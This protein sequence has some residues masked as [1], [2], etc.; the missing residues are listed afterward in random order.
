ME[1]IQ[2]TVHYYWAFAQRTCQRKVQ[3]YLKRLCLRFDMHF[4]WTQGLEVYLQV[5]TNYIDVFLSVSIDLKPR[6]LLACKVLFSLSIVEVV[7]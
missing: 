1:D 4:E 6:V 7:A 3:N 5:C 2:W